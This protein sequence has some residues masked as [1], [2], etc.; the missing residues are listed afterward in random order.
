MV[1]QLRVAAGDR[2]PINAML[3]CDVMLGLPGDM[4]VKVD[5]TSMAHALETRTPY[6]DQ[7]V[8]EWSFARPGAD[9]LS[10][11]GGRAVGKRIL[12]TAFQDRLPAEVFHRPK[13]GFEMPVGA[14][15][16]GPAAERLAAATDAGA[17]RRQGLLRPELIEQWRKD[18]ASGR[19][20][21]SWQLWTVLAFQEWARLHRRPEAL[22]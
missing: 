7:R 21:T 20:D 9:K 13:R 3:S 12:R 19:R 16:A 15:L 1:D 6:L 4:L 8:V 10:T 22:S 18:L 11:V 5:R 14:V 17:L 2:D